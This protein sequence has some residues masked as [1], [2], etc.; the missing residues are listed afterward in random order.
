MS[1]HGARN[2]SVAELS[3][4]FMN[5]IKIAWV[6]KHF[7][8]EPPFCPAGGIFFTGCNLRCVFCQNFQISQGGIGRE[9]SAEELAEIMLKLQADGSANIDLVTPTIW[10]KQIKEAI[11]IARDGGLKTPVLWNSNAYEKVEILREMEGFVDIYL[12]DFKYGIDAVGLKYSGARNYSGVATAA[13]K[14]MVRQVGVSDRIVVRHLVLP[15]NLENSFEALNKL[16]EISTD[17][18]VSLMNQ[19]SPLHNA[20][21]FPEINR[22]LTEDEFDNTFKFLIKKG[23]KNGW[24]QS[25]ESR[26]ILIPDFAKENPWV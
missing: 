21:N 17:L 25:A 14:E 19:Y 15:G 7:G 2:G 23:F 24:A 5:K 10:F 16:A 6:G 20:A 1:C 11:K 26:K 22:V 3:E 4:M 18:H 9:Y 12:P 13:I 8:E